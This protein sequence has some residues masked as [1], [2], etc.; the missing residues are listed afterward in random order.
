MYKIN[1]IIHTKSEQ[2]E[3][4]PLGDIHYGSKNCKIKKF[5]E[6]IKYIKDTPHAYMIGMGD[7]IDAI[8]PSDKR[9]SP[10][11]S[12]SIIDNHIDVMRGI[13][14][15]IKTKILCMLTGNHEHKLHCAGYGDP[16][17]RL[18]RELDISYGGFSCFI[19]II[20]T[21]KTHKR[22]LIIYAHHGWSAGRKTGNIVNNV[23]NL[24]QYWEADCYLV[25]H[26]HKLWATRQVRIGWAGE[27]KVIFGNTGTYLE[28][29]SWDT[30]GYGEKAGYPPQKLGC[31]KLK[32]YP[33][34][35]D[36]HISE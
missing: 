27:R 19:K 12:D 30:T 33:Y 1:K 32:Y 22:N 17:R 4:I 5:I 7:Y 11:N 28:T 24:S 15:P 8:L 16:T 31:L 21:P 10:E 29:C 34:K 13:L 25:G 3:I 2:V 9:F 35:D 23:E 36:I 26:S 18:C 6:Q 14:E 20:V